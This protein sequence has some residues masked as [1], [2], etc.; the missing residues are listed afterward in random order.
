VQDTASRTARAAGG[1]YRM[2]AGTGEEPAA[3]GSIKYSPW[4]KNKGAEDDE[5]QEAA[6]S[7]LTLGLGLGF[8]GKASVKFILTNTLS[9]C[10]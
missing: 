2:V 6:A 5:E 1:F 7:G 4:L 10:L 3:P 9:V 8:G